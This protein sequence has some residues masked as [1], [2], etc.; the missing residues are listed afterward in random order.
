MA[1][2]YCNITTDLI[3]IY[4][5]IEKFNRKTLVDSDD[6]ELVSG[7]IYKLDA[8][9]YVEMLYDDGVEM[10]VGSSSSPASGEFYYDS[11]ADI[12]YANT[13]GTI[14][15]STMH[16]GLNW[17]VFKERQRDIAQEMLEG[18]LKNIYPTPFQKIADPITSY[19]SRSYDYWIIKCTAILTCHLIISKLAP[20]D[21]EASRLYKM[22]YFNNPEVGDDIGYVQQMLN[23]DIVLRTQRSAREIGGFNVYEGDSNSSSGYMEFLPTQH[24]VTTEQTLKIVIDTAGVPGTAT[25]KLST[26]GGA[27]YDKT[28]QE[29]LGSGDDR[30]IEIGNNIYCRFVGTFVLNDEVT[31]HIFPATDPQL[32]QSVGNISLWRG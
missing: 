1:V 13:G 14:T 28:L 23:G 10:T 2:E 24:T 25:Y 16:I 31:L 12:L 15:S 6:W 30:R 29:T 26:D 27:T 3:D 9:G 22:V 5:D 17:D 20:M 19:E 32:S 11:A 18:W 7:T 21:P 4:H 8:S